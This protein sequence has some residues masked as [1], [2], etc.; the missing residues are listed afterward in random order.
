MKFVS[1]LPIALVLLAG[2]SA[3]AETVKVNG[4]FTS[5]VEFGCLDSPIGL[6]THGL[7]D[8]DLEGT[9]YFI[10]DSSGPAPT[11]K[12]PD[13]VVYTG[14]SIITLTSGEIIFGE[15]TGEMFTSNPFSTP[16]VTTVQVVGGEGDFTNVRGR[17]VA[18]GLINFPANFAVGSYRGKLKYSYDDDSDSDSDSDSDD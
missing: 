4:P 12:H 5:T 1:V 15:D 9:Y 10:F 2:T 13:R 7:L 17:I 3:S 8:G 6:C 18:S 11:R 16:F 14:R